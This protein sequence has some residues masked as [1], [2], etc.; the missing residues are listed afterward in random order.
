MRHQILGG[1]RPKIV[2]EFVGLLFFRLLSVDAVE[3]LE[4]KGEGYNHR[5]T[6]HDAKFVEENLQPF[7][8]TLS[9]SG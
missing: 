7:L 4:G 5:R 6:F 3:E 9:V 8:P 2:P 1:P